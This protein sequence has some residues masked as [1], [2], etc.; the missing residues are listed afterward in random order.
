MFLSVLL[1]S[2]LAGGCQ[3]DGASADE[4]AG[5]AW[6]TDI[7]GD[8]G[9]DF[10]HEAGAGGNHLLPE[11]M[12]GGCAL[13]DADGDGRLDLYLVNS[14]RSLNDD[15]APFRNRLYRQNEDGT[16][17]DA[18]ALSGLRDEGFGMGVAVGDIDNDG[19]ADVYVTNYGPDRLY[20]NVGGGRFEDVTAA[21]GI[22]MPGWSCSATFLDFDVDGY[23]DLFVTQYVVFDADKRCVGAAR[24][25]YCGPL[26]FPPAH[27]VLLR[28]NGD[29]TFRDVSKAAG[30]ASLQGAGL[31]VACEDFDDNGLVDVYVAN[32][33]YGNHLWI[34]RGDAAFEDQAVLL[35][36]A[37]NFH[38]Q[39]EA[40]MG[41][42]AADLNRDNLPDL[43]MTHLVVESNTYYRHLGK[44]RG[45]AD[46]TAAS[47]LAASSMVFTG[48]GVVAFDVELD[49]D[50]DLAVANGRVKAGERL[51]LDAP[52]NDYAEPNLFYLSDGADRFVEAGA[53]TAP[54]T[55][56]IEVSRGLAVGDI[57][58][59]GDLDVLITSIQGPARLY[60]N[61]A[62]R[63]GSWLR[64]RAIDPRYRRDAI[65]AVVVLE[66]TGSVQRRYVNGARG[67]LSHSDPAAHFG[68]PD[69][70]D[71]KRL[72][73]RWPDGRYETFEVPGKN[74][75]I[76][77]R[78]GEGRED[79]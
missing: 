43:F 8:S 65:G 78:R 51:A 61:E 70:E 74:L 45:F 47:G 57:D 73:V 33:A 23:L 71:P 5:R 37:Y 39:A 60:R 34:N 79:T 31:G 41:V 42:V 9:L 69:D 6:L 77:V 58:D 28:G 15:K 48:F 7:T 59:D 17:T 72:V 26:K 36:V 44:D 13:L 32:D 46:R 12:G 49:G 21:A 29:G 3:K 76:E 40:G 30:V 64:V 11:I 52:W 24:P 67:Y 1:I 63:K 66:S 38:G 10:I 4:I 50:L 27:D 68:I 62:P 35:G 75:A 56:P 18:T 14:N 22:D 16:F 20:R 25:D 2:S 19:R 54:F 55:A 53:R